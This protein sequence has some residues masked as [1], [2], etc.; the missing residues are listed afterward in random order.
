MNALTHFVRVPVRL[1][2][3]V[4][5]VL[6]L[7]A[8]APAEQSADKSASE[9]EKTQQQKADAAAQAKKDEIEQQKIAA[10]ANNYKKS[11]YT[12]TLKVKDGQT[13]RNTGSCGSLSQKDC[14]NS[15]KCL[16]NQDKKK[17]YVCRAAK[18]ACEIGFVQ[19]GREPKKSCEGKDFCKFTAASCFCP[20]GVQCVCGGGKPASCKT[21]KTS[22]F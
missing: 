15:S 21:L 12:P 18:G 2:T 5:L 19:L 1:C 9:V 7:V 20:E 6:M 3:Q 4:F 16:L 8:C 11:E 17:T 13:T 14:L 22:Q 10:Q